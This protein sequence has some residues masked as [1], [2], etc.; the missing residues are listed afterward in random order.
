MKDKRKLIKN[1]SIEYFQQSLKQLNDA[2]LNRQHFNLGFLNLLRDFFKNSTRFD[3]NTCAQMLN[4][5]ETS[6]DKLNTISLKNVRKFEF[7][8]TRHSS[9]QLNQ[10]LTLNFEY[11]FFSLIKIILVDDENLIVKE[12]SFFLL[13]SFCLRKCMCQYELFKSIIGKPSDDDQDE[14]NLLEL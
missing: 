2:H 10:H 4:T 12:K 7:Q 6:I 1:N 13:L 8:T 11:S 9:S 3:S 5:F 14:F